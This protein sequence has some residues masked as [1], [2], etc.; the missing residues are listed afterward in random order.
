MDHVYDN[1]EDKGELY[2]IRKYG[3]YGIAE[4]TG[5][6]ILPCKYSEIGDFVDGIAKVREPNSK[7]RGFVNCKGEEIIPCI[8][9]TVSDFHNG[10]ALVKRKGEYAH[11]IDK[12]GTTVD[13]EDVIRQFN[14][15][16][17]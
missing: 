17:W 2:V 4:L 11:Y 1:I 14:L 12:N 5:K 10:V 8:Y 15:V 13:D 9:K 16:N 6:V 7:R 3:L